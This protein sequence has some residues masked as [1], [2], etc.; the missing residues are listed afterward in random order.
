[1]TRFVPVLGLLAAAALAGCGSAATEAVAPA[2][3]AA[4][5][6]KHVRT[7]PKQA[8]VRRVNRICARYD[9]LDTTSAGELRRARRE[10]VRLGQPSHDRARWLRVMSKLKAIEGHIDTMRAADRAGSR[11]MYTLSARELDGSK[12]SATRR[13]R[14]FGATRCAP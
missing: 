6:P 8:F 12:A 3:P 9:V 7:L 4:A 14:R 10:L 1:V 5:K 2:A 13:I 11:T